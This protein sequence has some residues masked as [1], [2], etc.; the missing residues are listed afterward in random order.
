M[1]NF[2]TVLPL[3]LAVVPSLPVSHGAS[4]PLKGHIKFKLG[5]PLAE[6]TFNFKLKFK[7]PLTRTLTSLSARPARE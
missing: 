4:G 5:Q 7:V 2:M 3:T 6:H 1:R